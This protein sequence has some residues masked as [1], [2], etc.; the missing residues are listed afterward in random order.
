MKG[1]AEG[2]VGWIRWAV[3]GAVGRSDR[4]RD[5]AAFFCAQRERVTLS[6]RRPLYRLANILSVT[7][8]KPE[9]GGNLVFVTNPRRLD[10]SSPARKRK[11]A[12][13]SVG[14]CFSDQFIKRVAS[15]FPAP[16]PLERNPV[17]NFTET[18]GAPT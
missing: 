9:G 8:W 11:A 16:D 14:A 12:Q 1:E 10:F 13:R 17:M 6:E 5:V 4:C 7:G 18:N 2:E 15:S 3:V